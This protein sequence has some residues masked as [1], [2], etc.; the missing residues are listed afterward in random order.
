LTKIKLP[1]ISVICLDFLK[2]NPNGV[3]YFLWRSGIFISIGESEVDRNT[4][5][6]EVFLK[7]NCNDIMKLLIYYDSLINYINQKERNSILL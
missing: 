3:D 2:I 5:F 6:T 7:I 1:V 4:I